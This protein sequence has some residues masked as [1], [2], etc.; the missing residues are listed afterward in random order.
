MTESRGTRLPFVWLVSPALAIFCLLLVVWSASAQ[1]PTEADGTDSLAAQTDLR[2]NEFMAS[3][4]STL[5]DPDDPGAFPDWIELYNPTAAVVSLTGLSFSDDPA[6]PAKS[7][8]TVPLSIPANGFLILY[9]DNNPQAGPRHLDFALSAAGEEIGLYVT[10][11]GA[12]IDYHEFGPQ[13]QDR[14]EGR[15]PDGIGAFVLLDTPSPGVSNQ[16]APPL[17]SNVQRSITQPQQGQT[18]DVTAVVTDNESLVS[19]SLVYSTSGNSDI[20]LPMAN[21][22]GNTWG[23][24]IPA[25]A[26]GVH[27]TYLVR[28]VDNDTNRAETRRAGYVVGYVAPDLVINETVAENFGQVEDLDDPGEF[29]DWLEI[30]N[31]GTAAV[32]LNGLSLSDDPLEP[33]KYRIPSG[34]VAP[35]KGFVLVYLDDDPEQTNQAANRIHTNFGL[36]KNGEQIALYGAEGTVVIDGFSFGQQF[37]NVA[38]GFFPDGT[39]ARISLVCTTPGKKNM[40][41]DD[42][43]YLPVVDR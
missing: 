41:C 28:A 24:T 7:P 21:L 23:A 1:D 10:A 19:V 4:Q 11:T 37:D 22:S 43:N 9:A 13:L 25:Q 29:P 18:V 15:K 8:I 34:F 16:L 30:Y 27:V 6:N 35:A 12:E 42:V 38:L 33:T 20:A 36:S 40:L 3:N 26:T 14:S 5:S 31:P 39:G 32:S 17:I 2:I